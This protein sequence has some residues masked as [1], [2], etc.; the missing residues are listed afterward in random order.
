MP[1]TLPKLHFC[2]KAKI[3]RILQ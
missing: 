2:R 3:N 1:Q